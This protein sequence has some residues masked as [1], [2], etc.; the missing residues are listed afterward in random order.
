MLEIFLISIVKET[1]SKHIL[2][3]AMATT[4]SEM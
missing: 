4:P 3:W 2:K 1:Y